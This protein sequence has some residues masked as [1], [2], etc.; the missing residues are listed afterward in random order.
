[1]YDTEPTRRMTEPFVA[2]GR[3]AILNDQNS[4]GRLGAQTLT[5][6]AEVGYLDWTTL[7]RAVDTMR[8]DLL[9]P[10]WTPGQ[11]RP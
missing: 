10:S 1:M 6:V 11:P 2:L 7:Q 3:N 5:W 8:V 4:C 9:A